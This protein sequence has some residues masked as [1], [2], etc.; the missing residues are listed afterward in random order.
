MINTLSKLNLSKIGWE[1]E[2]VNLNLDN[3]FKYT[4]FVT[5]SLSYI[6]P[7]CFKQNWKPSH[8]SDI[9]GALFDFC[10]PLSVT[11]GNHLLQ[12]QFFLFSI[13]SRL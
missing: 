8:T 10:T 12:N 2:G 13:T 4:F 3:V 1:G 9:C 7:Y 11:L 6:F 5:L